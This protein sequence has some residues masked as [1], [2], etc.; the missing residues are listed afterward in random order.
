MRKVLFGVAL[1]VGLAACESRPEVW[2]ALGTPINTVGLA[3]SV[4]VKD[5]A[6]DRLVMVS[7]PSG[8]QLVTTVLPV[9]KN[10]QTLQPDVRGQRLF[11]LSNGAAKRTNSSDEPPS[12]SVVDGGGWRPASLT[13]TP[14]ESVHHSPFVLARYRLDSPAQKVDVDPFGEYAVIRVG[15][16]V[17][18]NPNQLLLV[19]LP[20][21]DADEEVPSSDGDL[22][23]KTIR[24][25]GSE[26]QQIMFTPKLQFP[27][28]ERRLLV[29][30]TAREIALI[31]LE[32]PE[33]EITVQLASGSQGG[34]PAPAEV[35]YHD[36]QLL[37]ADSAT[38]S[39]EKR[40]PIFAIRLANDSAVQV[41]TF[42]PGAPGTVTT[43]SGTVATKNLDF[44]V[45]VNLPDAGGV[46]SDIDFF[47]TEVNGS[48]ALRLAALVPSKK[49]AALIDPVT[50][51]AEQVDFGAMFDSMVRVTDEVGNEPKTSDV[52]LLWSAREKKIG[53]WNLAST[54][55]SAYRS[56]ESYPVD[57]PVTSVTSITR[58]LS[59]VGTDFGGYKLLRSND[60]AQEI[61]VLKLAERQ[62]APLHVLSNA[63]VG[64]S[65]D[66]QRLWV[67]SKG[68]TQF[69]AA[70]FSDLVPSNIS[71]ERPISALYDVAQ[72]EQG[73]RA[74]IAFH[75]EGNL[76]VTVLD[77]AHPDS[78]DT[79]FYSGLLLGGL[80]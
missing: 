31:D 26:P 46:P 56:L 40:Y 11:V 34:T 39:T 29:V 79:R 19:K 38:V 72:A 73:K 21:A 49:S 51:H 48:S 59:G 53:F 77:A 80:R 57:F 67:F 69:A 52:A 9:G 8:R 2:D 64:V 45:N 47:W 20:P 23:A 60:N 32:H 6:L 68:S 36:N 61:Y 62:T 43:A 17:V 25:F 37:S 14:S 76:G 70:S 41:L 55:T 74:V 58:D 1:V 24:S 63:S 30:Q 16:A 5:S 44:L 10:I 71:V 54:G 3:G 13:T 15:G 27:D 33:A 78:T 12:V 4:A 42:S 18:S 22:V 75:D 66:G 28:G 65:P 35:I 50:S 7:S